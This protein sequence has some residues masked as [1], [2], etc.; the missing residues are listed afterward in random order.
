MHVLVTGLNGFTGRYVQKALEARGHRVTG[1]KGDLIDAAAVA[2]EVAQ[3]QPDAVVHLAAIAFVNHGDADAFYQ[4]N[5]IGT[6]HLLEALVNHA[7]NVRSILLASSAN[8]YGNQTDGALSE[9]TPPNPANDYAV[10]KWAMEKMASLYFDRL[11]IFIVRP[12]NYTGVG[13][14]ENF[15]IPKIVSHFRQKKAEIELGNLDVWREFGDVRSVAN[16]Y[17]QLLELAP[18]GETLNVGTG[19]SHS[20]LEII[21]LCELV[22]KH[23]IIINVNP[24]L[25][26]ANEV[27]ILKS[28]TAR[29]NKLI[30]NKATSFNLED[31]LSWMFSI[32]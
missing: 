22:S 30:I 14:S 21:S 12:F 26:R 29:L 24:R 25:V 28:K 6:R 5:V 2:S 27:K 15:L 10:S 9:D 13:Q 18:R 17:C 1:L 32:N 4:V 23:K 3:I 19:H 31:T 8:V 11:P 16:I 20:L 7:P